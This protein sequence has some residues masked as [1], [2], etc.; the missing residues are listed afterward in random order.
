MDT[1]DYD[2][3]AV[4]AEWCA[5][6][7]SEVVDYLSAEGVEHG[8]VGEWPAWH[9]AP[10]VSLWAIES[11]ARS[12]WVGWWAIFGDLPTDYISAQTLK[13]PRD[14]VRAIA[15]R[16]LRY[17]VD[18]RE[19]RPPAEFGFRGE[20]PPDQLV[21]LLETRASVLSEWVDDD[22]VWEGL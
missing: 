8:E 18:V 19:G 7:R 20:T 16:W 5:L 13:H 14:A 6:A 9:V 12:G 11:K 15:E 1:P 22:S 10:V 4:E 2:D 3:P 17:A 21:P